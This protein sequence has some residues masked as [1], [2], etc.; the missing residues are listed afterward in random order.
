V[1]YELIDKTTLLGPVPRIADRMK[2]YATAGVT[3]LTLSPAGLTREQRL[4][5][6][7]AGVE[8]LEYAGLAA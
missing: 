2:A 7:R 3:T 4:S 8:A 1:P 5:T 6:L